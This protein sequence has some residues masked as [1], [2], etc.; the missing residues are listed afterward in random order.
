MKKEL[1]SNMATGEEKRLEMGLGSYYLI[2]RL[3]D[4]FFR[5]KLYSRYD[6]VLEKYRI[7]VIKI[8][9]VFKLY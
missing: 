4:E 5:V 9:E 8:D 7:P 2:K 6:E 1:L 3:D